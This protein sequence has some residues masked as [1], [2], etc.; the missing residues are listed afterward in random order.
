MIE[1]L[2]DSRGVPVTFLDLKIDPQ[3][4]KGKDRLTT[5]TTICFES[6]MEDPASVELVDVVVL[7]TSGEEP[8]LK[9]RLK[10]TEEWKFLPN[11]DI[12]S[13]DIGDIIIQ[14]NCGKNLAVMPTDEEKEDFK[15]Q[16]FIVRESG[17]EDGMQIIIE[18]GRFQKFNVSKKMLQIRCL[19]GEGRGYIWVFPR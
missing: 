12:Q 15:K 10:V 8:L 7:Q 6:G 4:L 9:K 5:H 17:I 1:G 14:N 13:N 18:P 19:C 16:I 2:A 3:A 11:G